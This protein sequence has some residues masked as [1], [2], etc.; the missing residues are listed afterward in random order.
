MSDSDPRPPVSLSLDDQGQPFPGPFAAIFITMAAFTTALFVTLLLSDQPMIMA[1][2]V[3]EAIGLG[4]VATLAARRVPEPQAER[5]GMRGFRIQLLL[6]VLLLLP[7]VILISEADNWVRPLFPAPAEAVETVEASAEEAPEPVD[8]AAE[9]LSDTS[10]RYE[11]IQT[12]IVAIGIQPV[13][14]AFLFF[15]VLLQGLV[16]HLGRTRGIAVTCFLYL[17]VHAPIA[18]SPSGAIVLLLNV[19][20]TSTLFS[21][22]RL[23]TGSILPSMLLAAGLGAIHLSAIRGGE[24]MVQIPGFNADGDHT[25][26]MVLLPC[27]AAVTYGLWVLVRAM[28]DAPPPPPVVPLPDEDDDEGFHF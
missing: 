26:L 22:A 23:A 7:V 3:G 24:W 12:A 15:G 9:P 17:V 20:V 27:V 21:I 25:P 2:G 5:L 16:A 28:L 6:P 14:N 1:A 11:T 10:M 4:G 19:I 8:E 18:D 13:V